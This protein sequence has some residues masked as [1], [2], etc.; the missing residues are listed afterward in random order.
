LLRRLK[1]Y[2]DNYF[3]WM[4]DFSLPTTN[5]LSERALR[6]RKITR[7]DIRSIRVVN[8]DCQISRNNKDVHINLPQKWHK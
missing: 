2:H 8:R 6:G 3:A 7:K 1:K 4:K 5:N